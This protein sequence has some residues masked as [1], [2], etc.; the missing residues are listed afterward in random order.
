MDPVLKQVRN[1][2]DEVCVTLILNTHHTHP[3]SDKDVLTLKNLQREAERILTE[4][5]EKRLAWRMIQRLEELTDKIDHRH[6]IESLVV[7]VSETVAVY[8]R[9]PVAVTDRVVVERSFAIRDLIRATHMQQAYY[10]LVLGK[11]RVRLIE[12]ANGRV[13]EEIGRPFPMVNN[14]LFAKNPAEGSNATRVGNFQR[15]FFKMA[16]DALWAVWRENPH[17]VVIAGDEKRYG[18]FKEVSDH[19]DLVIGVFNDDF[20]K[21]AQHIVEDNWHLVEDYIRKKNDRRI[22]E[23]KESMNSNKAL[24]D[25][26]EIWKAIREGRGQTLFVKDGCYLTAKIV[27]D[28][29]V[30]LAGEKADSDDVIDDVINEMIEINAYYGGDTVFIFDDG[31]DQ[32]GGLALVIRY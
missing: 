12:A 13:I 27:G 1:I 17:P 24:F 22:A 20:D 14:S 10:T 23:L 9:L 15:E 4:T 7:F 2:R 25:I 8:T 18:R 28:G 30:P 5:L 6:N 26:N 21:S 29:I 3:D 16:D 31:L 11:D 32:Y 19:M